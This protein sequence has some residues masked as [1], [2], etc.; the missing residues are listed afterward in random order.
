MEH[1]QFRKT[2]DLELHRL[3][4][5][6]NQN[7]S[8]KTQEKKVALMQLKEHFTTF[9]PRYATICKKYFDGLHFEA[10]IY[11]VA[12]HMP[13]ELS[14]TLKCLPK[15]DRTEIADVFEQK[16]RSLAWDSIEFFVSENTKSYRDRLPD[17]MSTNDVSVVNYI[18]KEEEE[19][20]MQLY[21]ELVCA[22]VKGY[23]EGELIQISTLN[24]LPF[25]LSILEKSYSPAINAEYFFMN[26]ENMC[27]QDT[28]KAYRENLRIWYQQKKKREW[29]WEE[30]IDERP[31][32]EARRDLSKLHYLFSDEYVDRK[33]V[34]LMDYL[35]Q[36]YEDIK[37]LD[38]PEHLILSK[39]QYIQSELQK[40]EN[41]QKERSS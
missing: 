20:I 6:L 21:K 24:A 29:K 3:E 39:F 25:A 14:W 37:A 16:I 32:K 38:L 7:L 18:S 12:L 23:V 27:N 17:L 41:I 30:G 34:E 8:K 11:D 26:T 2:V 15:E 35:I 33:I 9:G 40:I 28:E 10:S 19:E 22:L 4:Q 13:P 1:A 36:I 31:I 5:K